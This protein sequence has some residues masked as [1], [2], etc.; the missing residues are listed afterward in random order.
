VLSSFFFVSTYLFFSLK[1]NPGPPII[2]AVG[3]LEIYPSGPIPKAVVTEVST[4]LT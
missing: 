2:F 4:P 3:L 1:I